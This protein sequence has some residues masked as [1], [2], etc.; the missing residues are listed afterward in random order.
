MD[1]MELLNKK[2]VGISLADI[3]EVVG[4]YGI[5][6]LAVFGS[7]MREDFSADSDIDLLIEF[8]NSA[9]ISLFDLID[10]Q[11]YFESKFKRP[12]DL[13]EPAGLRNPYRKKAILDGKAI[14]YVA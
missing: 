9:I 4:R 5:K 12:V 1:A 14:L 2:G 8:E 10:I 11:S 13:V 6:E 7:V 3:K